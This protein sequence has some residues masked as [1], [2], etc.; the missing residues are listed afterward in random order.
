MSVGTGSKGE[1][2][3]TGRLKEKSQRMIDTGEGSTTI[4]ISMTIEKPMDN[5][6]FMIRFTM[7]RGVL[8]ELS[9]P[10]YSGKVS[11]PLVL[12]SLQFI[13]SV[14]VCHLPSRI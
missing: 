4:L 2:T 8:V 5:T 10:R 1:N 6:W 7:K 3:I 14:P 12:C 9:I 13:E 11:T